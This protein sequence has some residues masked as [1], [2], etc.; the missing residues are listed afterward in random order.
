MS[1]V[2]L[3]RGIFPNSWFL[4]GDFGFAAVPIE[5]QAAGLQKREQSHSFLTWLLLLALLSVM[6]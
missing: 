4:A 2:C 6:W 5:L 3:V 1:L